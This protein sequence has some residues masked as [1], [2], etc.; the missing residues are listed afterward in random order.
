MVMSRSGEALATP[1]STSN[2]EYLLS[3]RS[4]EAVMRSLRCSRLGRCAWQ[5]RQLLRQKAA[6][7]LHARKQ[8]VER[9]ELCSIASLDCVHALVEGVAL[10]IDILDRAID[11]I[12]S[13]CEQAGVRQD[14]IEHGIEPLRI[15]A[16]E[17][18]G[19]P[20]PSC[21]ACDLESEIAQGCES[22]PRPHC[23]RSVD[24]S[25]DI[26]TRRTARCV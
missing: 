20:V 11:A 13:S 17:R 7:A 21:A 26:G 22:L 19:A 9:G 16:C 2:A 3:A 1:V 14:R 10:V 4:T 18:N 12:R 6:C 15:S 23:R 5:A 24:R 8:R 25:T